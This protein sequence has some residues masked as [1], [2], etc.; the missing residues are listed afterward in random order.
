MYFVII[1]SRSVTVVEVDHVNHV[2]LITEAG[3]VGFLYP[4]IS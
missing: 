1:F 4:S 3:S 2:A